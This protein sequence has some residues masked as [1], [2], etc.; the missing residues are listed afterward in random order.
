[1]STLESWYMSNF[2]FRFPIWNSYCWLINCCVRHRKCHGSQW[3]HKH[4]L[5]TF[6]NG[7]F[8]KSRPSRLVATIYINPQSHS[9]MGFLACAYSLLWLLQGIESRGAIPGL[10]CWTSKV[11]SLF[12]APSGNHTAL[13]SEWT[14]VPL[15]HCRN[16]KTEHRLSNL[17]CSQHS[18]FSGTPPGPVIWSNHYRTR[19]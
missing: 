7:V 16:F 10:P 15:K 6:N 9:S 17:A 13:Y 12:W 2:E 19:E 4:E 3:P 8:H 18:V 14:P 11:G 1:M 5:I